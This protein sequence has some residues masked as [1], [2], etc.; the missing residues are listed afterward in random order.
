MQPWRFI[1]ITKPELR[2][3]LY[4][5][6]QQERENTAQALADKQQAFRKL[7]VEGLKDCAEVIAVVLKPDREQHIFGRRT[8]PQMDLAS[9]AC[10][11]QNMWLAAR[12]EGIGVGWVSIFDPQQVAELLNLPDG[13]ETIALLCLG[14]VDEFYQT[15]MLEQENWADREDL[16]QLLMADQ[17][18]QNDKELQQAAPNWQ[19]LAC[20]SDNITSSEP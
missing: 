3:A 18:A 16:N 5:S 12:A 10:A 20:D 9:A 19:S 1:R 13:C 8:L 4:Q 14:Y 11:I 15:P 6:V 2:E 7:K 17:W